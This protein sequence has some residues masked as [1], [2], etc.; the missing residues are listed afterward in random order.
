MRDGASRFWIAQPIELRGLADH[1]VDDQRGRIAEL[2]EGVGEFRIFGRV[3]G[4]DD[5]PPGF[6]LRRRLLGVKLGRSSAIR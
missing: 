5:R 3:I 6:S 4:V 1:V 2:V